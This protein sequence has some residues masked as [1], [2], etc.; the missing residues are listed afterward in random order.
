MVDLMQTLH[1][2]EDYPSRTDMELDASS[3]DAKTTAPPP[4]LACLAP[5]LLPRLQDLA[6]SCP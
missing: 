5:G 1:S 3:K 6:Q 2:R 4:L